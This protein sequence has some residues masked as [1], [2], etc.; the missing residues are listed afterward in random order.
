ML[1][2]ANYAVMATLLQK[3]GDIHNGIAP[4]VMEEMK[5]ADIMMV[6]NEF[7]YSC[8]F[9][10]ELLSVPAT[11]DPG[12]S[13]CRALSIRII[14]PLDLCRADKSNFQRNEKR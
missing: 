11:E 8:Y 5:S 13:L 1:F 6:N 9:L 2:D 7:A 14:Q 12:G 10:H 3:G 4:E